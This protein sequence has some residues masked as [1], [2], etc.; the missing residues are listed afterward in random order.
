M[1]RTAKKQDPQCPFC[2]EKLSLT[3]RKIVKAGGAR[4]VIADWAQHVHACAIGGASLP[5]YVFVRI[6]TALTHMA[7]IGV[8]VWSYQPF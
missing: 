5:G 8:R 6:Q 7:D 4:T 1:N 3:T 2:G